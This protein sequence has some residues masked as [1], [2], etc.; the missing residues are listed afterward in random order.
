MQT[1]WS[2][3]GKGSFKIKTK[4]QIGLFKPFPFGQLIPNFPQIFCVFLLRNHHL[5]LV[6]SQT[7]YQNDKIEIFYSV[8]KEH[9]LCVI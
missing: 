7:D 3:F 5:Y 8:K 6:T 4:W 2:V 1:D 9:S